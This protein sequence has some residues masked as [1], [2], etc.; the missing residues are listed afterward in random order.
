MDERSCAVVII[1]A[2]EHP[3]SYHEG[4]LIKIGPQQL[5]ESPSTLNFFHAGTVLVNL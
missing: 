4:D 1:A 2:G 5:M 3:R